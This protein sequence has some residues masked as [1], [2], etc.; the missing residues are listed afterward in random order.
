MAVGLLVLEGRT[1]SQALDQVR[2]VRPE[3]RLNEAQLEWLTALE[4]Q[5]GSQPR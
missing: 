2:A 3:M 5:F 1:L 4:K